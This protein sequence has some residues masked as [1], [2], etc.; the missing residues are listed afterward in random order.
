MKF[1][2]Q[3][4]FQYF[5]EFLILK[6]KSFPKARKIDKR[7]VY[8]F[9]VSGTQKNDNLTEFGISLIFSR[10]DYDRDL[11][12]SYEDFV[13]AISPIYNYKI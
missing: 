1:H 4:Q 12:I 9:L 3:Y 10:F 6:G 8:N 13:R 7:M 11:M 5:E 2:K